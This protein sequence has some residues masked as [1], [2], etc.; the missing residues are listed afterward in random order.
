[1]GADGGRGRYYAGTDTKFWGFQE[2]AKDRQTIERLSKAEVNTQ[3]VICTLEVCQVPRH[4]GLAWTSVVDH[5]SE[6]GPPFASPATR[7]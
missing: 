4:V 7:Y 3:E 2:R 1:M 5:V 6:L